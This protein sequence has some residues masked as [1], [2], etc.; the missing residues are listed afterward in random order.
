MSDCGQLLRFYGEGQR[1]FGDQIACAD[2]S[3]RAGE[4]TP[5]CQLM[6]GAGSDKGM[7]WHNYTVLYHKL[8]Q[9]LMPKINIMLEVGIGTNYTDVPSNMGVDG[10]PGASLRGWREYFSGSVI[11]GG[12]VDDRILFEEDR[13]RTYKIDQLSKES[14]ICFKSVMPHIWFDVIIDDGLHTFEANEQL[15]NNISDKLRPGGFYIIEDI[16]TDEENIAK[17]ERLLNQSGK[18]GFLYNLPSD[19]NFIDNAVAVLEH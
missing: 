8:F 11:C 12:D 16:I 19:T 1:I 14:I 10:I 3:L 6:H 18:N 17:F 9:S 2:R 5:L 7:G 13:I 15:Y 4:I